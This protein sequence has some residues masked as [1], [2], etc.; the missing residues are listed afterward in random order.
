M[1]SEMFSYLGSCYSIW[2]HSRVHER[3]VFANRIFTGNIS[4]QLTL[5]LMYIALME[6]IEN[7]W[8]FFVVVLPN[9]F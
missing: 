1:L 6:G 3:I 2:L 9:H 5:P 7:M 8:S 4:E